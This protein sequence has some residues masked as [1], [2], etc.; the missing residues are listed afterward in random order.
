M[1]LISLNVGR[2]RHVEWYGEDITTSIFKTPVDGPLRVQTLGL[3]GNEQAD[4]TV[5]GG[6]N[7]AVY[8]YASE[9]YV[10]WREQLPDAHFS[11]GAFGEN[12]TLEGLTEDQVYIGDRLAIGTAEFVV[13]QPRMPCYKLGIRFDRLDMPKRFLASGF[14][15][16]YL[17]VTREGM[18]QAGETV[19]LT[20]GDRQRGTIADVF[21][22]KS[23]PTS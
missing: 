4:L 16:F 8:A 19:T 2:A 21:R 18:I 14:S 17:A 5:H 7:K 11:W 12:L 1:K 23:S 15:G 6:V 9:R 13:T 10:Y 22:A 3:A 20:P